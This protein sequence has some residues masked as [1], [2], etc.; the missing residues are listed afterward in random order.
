MFS[1]PFKNKFKYEIYVELPRV[2]GGHCNHRNIYYDFCI[3]C[4]ERAPVDDIFVMF[5]L[6]YEK[7]NVS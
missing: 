2:K 1:F 7:C 4:Q 3:A 5:H 6:I